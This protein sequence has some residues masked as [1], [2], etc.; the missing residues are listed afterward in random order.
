MFAY[1]LTFNPRS[2]ATNIGPLFSWGA[3]LWLGR[4]CYFYNLNVCL[5]IF[6][7]S[8]KSWCAIFKNV[9]DKGY[10]SYQSSSVLYNSKEPF[11]SSDFLFLP[12]SSP[13]FLH[14]LLQQPINRS[15]SSPYFLFVVWEQVLDVSEESEHS[16][17]RDENHK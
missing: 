3:V 14:N 7:Y 5:K 10:S 16:T 17:R 15:Q 1:M 9:L 13:N 6:A 11:I 2:K 8:S 4:S 12:S